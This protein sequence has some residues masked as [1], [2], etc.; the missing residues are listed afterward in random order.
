M[1]TDVQSATHLPRSAP[2]RAVGITIVEVGVLRI[3]P[4]PVVSEAVGAIAL[5]IGAT[6]VTTDWQGFGQILVTASA[7]GVVGLAA[8]DELLPTRL[9]RRVLAVIGVF[10]LLQAKIAP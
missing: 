2:A 3:T 5:L 8:F 7:V 1:T 9:E 10:A 4:L 6:I